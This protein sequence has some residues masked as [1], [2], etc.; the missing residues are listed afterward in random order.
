VSIDDLT[1]DFDPALAA[2]RA[3][4]AWARASTLFKR[5]AE[6]ISIGDFASAERNRRE[7]NEHAISGNNSFYRI[8]GGAQ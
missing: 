7:A 2:R 8:F 1:K 4:A 5:A 6:D 3:E